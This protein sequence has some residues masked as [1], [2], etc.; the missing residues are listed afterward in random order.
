M[1]IKH[2]GQVTDS[3]DLHILKGNKT[4]P[5]LGQFSEQV[6]V[7]GE[8]QY[9]SQWLTFVPADFAED[10]ELSG[11]AFRDIKKQ[12]KRAYPEALEMTEFER[13]YIEPV[14]AMDVTG[15]ITDGKLKAVENLWFTGPGMHPEGF[16]SGDLL[17]ADHQWLQIVDELQ[18]VSTQLES[19]AEL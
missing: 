4:E 13:L 10:E 14:A 8:T 15:V 1:F 2:T 7:L 18:P 16:L 19:S 5:C 9:F 6:N 17:W 11:Q 12:I 3:K